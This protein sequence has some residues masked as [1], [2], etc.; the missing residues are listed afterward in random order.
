V[1]GAFF[2]ALMNA[3]TW[4]QRRYTNFDPGKIE[5]FSSASRSVKTGMYVDHKAPAEDITTNYLLTG[6][7]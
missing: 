7:R 2:A 1:G 4:V 3:F 6:C 5:E